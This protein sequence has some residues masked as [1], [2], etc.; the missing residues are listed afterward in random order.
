MLNTLTGKPLVIDSGN[1]LFRTLG[2]ASDEDKRRASFVLSTMGAL[3][4]NVLGVGHRDLSAGPEFLIAEAK[5]ANVQLVSTNL[6]LE[7]KPAFPKSLVV[8]KNGVK[9]AVLSVT[10]LGPVPGVMGLMGTAQLPALLAELKKLPARDLTIVLCTS[11]YE[12][13]MALAGSLEASV[14]F[15]IQSGE[16]RGTVP[17]QKVKDLFLLAS[18]QRGQAVGKLELSLG[19]TKGAFA[20]LNEAARDQELLTN[21]ETQLKSVDERLK[22]AKDAEGKKALETLRKDMKAR[23]DEQAKRLT[24]A[25]GGR[26][27]KLDWL[28]LGPDV[29]D[30]P[31]LKAEVLKIEPSYEGLH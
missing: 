30:D 3:G 29:K 26:T 22:L 13:A 18:G 19:K 11:G 1:A 24:K 10:G 20:D 6:E 21:L 7:G 12:E 9:V 23:R 14:D 15:V 27:L 31:A 28:M 25:V 8:E 4:T 2:G 5:K 17:P 16:F